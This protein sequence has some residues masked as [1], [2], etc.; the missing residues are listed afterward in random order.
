MCI[1][2]VVSTVLGGVIG[3]WR[4]SRSRVGLG[5]CAPA[6]L[7]GDFNP[8]IAAG[9]VGKLGNGIPRALIPLQI[10]PLKISP[11]Q[12]PGTPKDRNL[13]PQCVFL[14]LVST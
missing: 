14:L 5:G 6:G 11:V 13:P 2:L 7:G 4:G 9:G 12:T 1:A 3:V 8:R 10:P